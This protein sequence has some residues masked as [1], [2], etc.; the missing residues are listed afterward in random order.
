MIH[1]F[2]NYGLRTFSKSKEEVTVIP[3][4]RVD[5]KEKE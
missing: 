1:K 4:V 3:Y 2:A 5:V